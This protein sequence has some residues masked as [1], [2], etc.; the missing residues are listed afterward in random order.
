MMIS[1][2]PFLATTLMRLY[3]RAKEF[4]YLKKKQSNLILPIILT[5]EYIE[6]IIKKKKSLSTTENTAKNFDNLTIFFKNLFDSIVYT[7]RMSVL[8]VSTS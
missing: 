3:L 6:E 7:K 5:F 1:R 8:S 2:R 4:Q